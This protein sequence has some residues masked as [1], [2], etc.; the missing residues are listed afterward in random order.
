[1]D[2]FHAD[3]G[4]SSDCKGSVLYVSKAENSGE[5]KD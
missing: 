5:K 2:R 1:V 3:L 4:E